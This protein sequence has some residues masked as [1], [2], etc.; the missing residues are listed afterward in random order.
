MQEP[1]RNWPGRTS[2]RVELE[3]QSGTRPKRPERSRHHER[4]SGGT[5]SA[6]EVSGSLSRNQGNNRRVREMRLKRRIGLL[7]REETKIDVPC[8]TLVV[9]TFRN[10][11]QWRKERLYQAQVRTVHEVWKSLY[12]GYGMEARKDLVFSDFSSKRK[13]INAQ[14]ICLP[15]V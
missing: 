7:S 10:M 1:N 6:R 12:Q 8:K 5:D 3:K 2:V 14:A 11:I 13:L 4:P 9:S 15:E